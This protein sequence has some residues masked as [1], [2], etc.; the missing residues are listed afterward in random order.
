[1]RPGR[2]QR[3]GPVDDWRGDGDSGGG[4]GGGGPS[5]GNGIVPAGLE[6]AVGAA[7]GEAGEREQSRGTI[8]FAYINTHI[9]VVFSHFAF[10]VQG[11][12]KPMSI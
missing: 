4:G 5:L 2:R 8:D 12:P 1:M 10:T 6:A 9:A 11:K 3:G 7:R